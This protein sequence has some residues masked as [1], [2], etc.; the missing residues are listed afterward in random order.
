MTVREIV[1]LAA[2][3]LGILEDVR[4]YFDDGVSAGKAKA[5]RLLTCYNLVEN[6]LA[7][8]Y[9]T[10]EKSEI[11]MSNGQVKFSQLE[12]APVKIISVTDAENNP[13]EFALYADYLQTVKGAVRITYAYTPNKKTIDDDCDFTKEVSSRLMSY[14]IA[15][16]YALAVGSFEEA[17]LWD[18]K[19]KDAIAVLYKKRKSSRIQSRRWA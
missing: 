7:L 14:G 17:A 18:K 5:E 13:Y 1:D 8:D 16:E 15:A 10:L 12:N 11:V 19:Y 3:E 9:F 4:E 6:E 2:E